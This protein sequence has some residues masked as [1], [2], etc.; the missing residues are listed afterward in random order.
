MKITHRVSQQHTSDG[1]GVKI[2]RIAGF[3]DRRLDPILMI[4]ELRSNNPDDYIGGFPP[5]PHRGME[6]FTYIKKGGFEHRDHLGNREAIRADGTQWMSTGKGVLHSEMPLNDAKEGMHGFQIWINMP[7]KDKMRDP[8]Y[9]DSNE[10]GNPQLEDANGVTLRA[11]SGSWDWQA[12]SATAA[13]TDT[14]A[15]TRI[16]DIHIPKGQSINLGKLDET[17]SGLFIYQGKLDNGLSNGNEIILFEEEGDVIFQ[18]HPD[19]DV[20][21]LLFVAEPIEEPVAHYGP[22]VMNTE[23]EIQQAVR[24][25]Q[26]GF[27]GEIRG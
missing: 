24:D 11:L 3:N 6:T 14:S 27:F 20:D 7:A 13:I 10:K 19:T 9:Q 15:K 23:R 26:N 17:M 1:D 8:L 12:Q 18:A 5:H 16:A 25:Y 22:F 21:A 4:D 2:K